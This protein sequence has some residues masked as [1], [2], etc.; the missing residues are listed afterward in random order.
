MQKNGH[1][2]DIEQKEQFSHTEWVVHLELEGQD[3][4][5]L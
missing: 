1:K 4:A 5:A 3:Y 2:T